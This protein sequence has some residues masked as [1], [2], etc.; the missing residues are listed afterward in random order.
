MPALSDLNNAMRTGNVAEFEKIA[1]AHPELLYDE[2]GW[3]QWLNIAANRGLLPFVELLVSLGVDVNAPSG[4]QPDDTAL[5][6]AAH[7]GH[8]D[9]VRWLLDHGAN[10][11]FTIKKEVR[12]SALTGAIVKG[13]ID[14]VK[15]LVERGA[16]VN[17]TGGSATPL[18]YAT[19]YKRTE[20]A[21][22]L[23]SAGAK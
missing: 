14:V 16:D 23:R 18:G 20:I 10:V 12:C 5:D 21:D 11:N 13:H 2:D 6:R 15:L 1:R 3:E 4:D 7:E 22:L 9:I 17:A 19:Q 8:L